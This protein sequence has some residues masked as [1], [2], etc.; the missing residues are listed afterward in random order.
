MVSI[1][2]EFAS[3]SHTAA[4]QNTCFVSSPHLPSTLQLFHLVRILSNNLLDFSESDIGVTERKNDFVSFMLI[5]NVAV[6]M[7]LR[8]FFAFLSFLK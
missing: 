2:S 8:I 3:E 1:I 4:A 5:K 6:S 7:L